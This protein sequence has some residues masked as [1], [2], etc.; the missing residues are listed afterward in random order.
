MHRPGDVA[1][2][3]ADAKAVFRESSN[4]PL[5]TAPSGC[6]QTSLYL[7]RDVFLLLPVTEGRKLHPCKWKM[8]RQTPGLVTYLTVVTNIVQKYLK[9]VSCW[10]SCSARFI[11]VRKV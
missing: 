11:M 3:D 10:P 8:T 9:E 5:E 7:T 2:E 4:M 1:V 6:I